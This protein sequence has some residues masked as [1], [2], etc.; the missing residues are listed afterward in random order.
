MA[1]AFPLSPERTLAMF[2]VGDGHSGYSEGM[3]EE[4]GLVRITGAS[5]SAV[6]GSGLN[7]DRVAVYGGWGYTAT[8]G[9]PFGVVHVPYERAAQVAVA[10]LVRACRDREYRPGTQLLRPA[11]HILYSVGSVLRTMGLS[12]E[13]LSNPEKDSMNTGLPSCFRQWMPSTDVAYNTRSKRLYHMRSPP[14][15]MSP[16]TVPYV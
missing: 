1:A 5:I 2:K 9:K 4:N 14:A 7:I 16:R 13:S 8:A 6:L 3:V 12:T 15:S 10:H 11:Y